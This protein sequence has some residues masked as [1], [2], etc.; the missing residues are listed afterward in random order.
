MDKTFIDIYVE[1]VD[2]TPFLTAEEERELLKRRHDPDA[3]E[4][5]VMS[6]QKFVAWCA[7]RYEGLMDWDDLIQEGNI[8]LLK[9][10]DKFDLN[11]PG[12]LETYAARVIRTQIWKALQKVP[13]IR[14]PEGCEEIPVVS[15]DAFL[16]DEDGNTLLDLIPAPKEPETEKLQEVTKY[17]LSLLSPEEQDIIHAVFHGEKNMKEIG[18]ERGYTGQSIANFKY[19]ALRKLRH[20]DIIDDLREKLGDTDYE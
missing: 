20:P 13:M 5:L 12:R 9:A 10:I 8:G 4:K 18:Q 11:Q 16:S 3:R 1:T 2:N 7:K 19:E 15:Y 14:T 17:S 6:N